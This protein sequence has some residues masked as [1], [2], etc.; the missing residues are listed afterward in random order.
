MKDILSAL[1]LAIIMPLSQASALDLS[2]SGIDGFRMFVSNNGVEAHVSASGPYT[3]ELAAGCTTDQVVA[4]VIGTTLSVHTADQSD[5][6]KLI[7]TIPPGLNVYLEGTNGPATFS[8]PAKTLIMIAGNGPLIA[9]KVAGNAA[10]TTGNGDITVSGA[11][12]GVTATAHNGK[13]TATDLK[14]NLNLN[15]TNGSLKAVKV[16][17][18]PRSHNYL[19]SGNGSVTVQNLSSTTV[20]KNTKAGIKVRGHAENGSFLVYAK[21]SGRIRRDGVF[22]AG[23]SPAVLV[24]TTE[25]GDVLVR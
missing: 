13:I 7:A 20:R 3:A 2:F 19:R 24:L 21:N 1:A 8:G 18:L 5:D 17:V 10:L 6:C 14:G 11:H 9:W 4:E 15:A 23:P 25:N 12:S 22:Q 16:V